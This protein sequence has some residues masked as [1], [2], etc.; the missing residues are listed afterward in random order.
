M[1][2]K[3]FNSVLAELDEAIT[4]FIVGNHVDARIS[5]PDY[6]IDLLISEFEKKLN[7]KLAKG[8]GLN[9]RG[10]NIIPS[11][12]NKIVVFTLDSPIHKNYK[13]IELQ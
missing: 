7:I 11:Y 2:T 3:T 8:N 1:D 12:E 10:V 13:V 5:M 4:F 6:F 9:Y